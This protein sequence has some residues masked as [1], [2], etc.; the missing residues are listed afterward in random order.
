MK[1]ELDRLEFRTSKASVSKT[2]TGYT[3][4][5]QCTFRKC[6]SSFILRANIRKNKI[7]KTLIESIR[8]FKFICVR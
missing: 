3:I 1:S 2:L 5:R 7:R 4:R 6:R 8:L